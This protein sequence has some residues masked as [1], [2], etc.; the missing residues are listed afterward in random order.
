MSAQLETGGR[1]E[2]VRQEALH[3]EG[4]R[5]S[6]GLLQVLDLIGAERR[7]QVALWGAQEHEPAMWLAILAEEVGEVA[8]EIAEGRLD[9]FHSDDYRTELIHVAAVAAA[10]IECLDRG[11]A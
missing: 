4:V 10:A 5:G 1:R 2:A 9:P 7:R 8:K 3:A 11:V 6:R